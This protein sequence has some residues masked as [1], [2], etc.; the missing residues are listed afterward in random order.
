VFGAVDGILW[1]S[2]E[3]FC[4]ILAADRFE[5]SGDRYIVCFSLL[6]FVVNEGEQ[7]EVGVECVYFQK[8]DRS[9]ALKISKIFYQLGVVILILPWESIHGHA[10]VSRQPPT[11]SDGEP[12]TR[13]PY[14]PSY[15]HPKRLFK[16]YPHLVDLFLQCECIHLAWRRKR[17]KAAPDPCD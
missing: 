9:K 1:I 5:V 4:C 15:C 6:R 10:L 3:P 17:I 14:S 16:Q 2:W 8:I 13:L 11:S 7:R 12:C